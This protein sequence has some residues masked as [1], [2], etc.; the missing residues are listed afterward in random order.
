[1]ITHN[2]G[3]LKNFNYLGLHRYSLTLCTNGRRRLFTERDNV[4]LVVQQLLR[5]ATEEKFAIVVYCFMPDHVHLLAQGTADDSDGKRF[6][7]TFKQY[8]GYYYSQ[9]KHQPLW[10]RYAFEHVLRDDEATLEV[11][12]YILANPVRA[13]L[14]DTVESYPFVGSL[15]YELKDLIHSASA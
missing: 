8:S 5:A 12:R 14:A 2:P 11:V 13:G 7:K 10:Q 9:A 1:M 3:H 6:I 4:E 15:A